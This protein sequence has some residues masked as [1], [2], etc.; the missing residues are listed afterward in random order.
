MPETTS[1]IRKYLKL[2]KPTWD[3]IQVQPNI[4]LK[5]IEPL[6]ERMSNK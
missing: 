3:Y 5:N 1:K 6:F 2:E 4:E